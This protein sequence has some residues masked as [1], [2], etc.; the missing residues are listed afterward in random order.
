MYTWN[1]QTTSFRQVIAVMCVFL[2]VQC[3]FLQTVPF[4]IFG[5]SYGGKMAASFAQMLHNERQAGNVRVDI[6]GFAMG[7]A[8]IHPVDSTLSWAPFL[9]ANVMY[10]VIHLTPLQSC[11]LDFGILYI[12]IMALSLCSENLGQLGLQVS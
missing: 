10:T 3:I 9:F 6:R 2:P 12:I 7:N 4:Y 1:G 11:I 8:W 5:Q